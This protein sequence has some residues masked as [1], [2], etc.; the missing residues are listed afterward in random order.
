MENTNWENITI[1]EFNSLPL[2]ERNRLN[3]INRLLPKAVRQERAMKR[4]IAEDHDNNIRC[5]R[6]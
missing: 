3:K 6:Y 5:G 2:W 4:Q 1:G